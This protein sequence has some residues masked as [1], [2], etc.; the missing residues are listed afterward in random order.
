VVSG[1]AIVLP[2]RTTIDEPDPY[3]EAEDPGL[4]SWRTSS[5]TPDLAPALA[6]WRGLY[7]SPQKKEAK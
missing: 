4:E 2:V 7:D 3:P 1:E 5:G 6:K